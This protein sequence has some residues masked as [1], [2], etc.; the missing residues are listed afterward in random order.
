MTAHAICP[1]CGY[2][3]VADQP[4]ILGDY[5]ILGTGYPICFRGKP[6]PLTPMEANICAALMK[7]YPKAVKPDALLIRL[8]SEGEW[9]IAQVL[10]CKVR[11][12][13]A[14]LGL[15]N[16]IETMRIVGYRWRT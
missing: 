7:V 13:F 1:S 10:V 3:L 11:R 9:N 6:L 4:I 5:S 8:G 16:P 2:D 12:K 14:E 15:N